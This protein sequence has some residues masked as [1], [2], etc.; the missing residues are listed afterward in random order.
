MEQAFEKIIDEII[1]KIHS[2]QDVVFKKKIVT[3]F[4]EYEE[5]IVLSAKPDDLGYEGTYTYWIYSKVIKP[6]DTNIIH[7]EKFLNID[8]KCKNYIKQLLSLGYTEE[9]IN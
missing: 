1:N 3:L 4:H 8:D 6:T 5:K 2:G 9:N 7:N